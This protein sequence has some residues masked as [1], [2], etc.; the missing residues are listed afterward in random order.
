[1]ALEDGLRGSEKRS[2][3]ALSP[4]LGDESSARPQ[5]RCDVPH[6]G[7]GILNPV[8][9]SIRKHRIERFREREPH[10]IGELKLE[11]GIVLAGLSDHVGR[12]INTNDV[13]PWFRDLGGQ[14]SRTASQVKDAFAGLRR[15]QRKHVRAEVPYKRVPSF[16]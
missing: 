5:H 16:V 10:G 4:E 14:L 13:R 7:F 9:D 3:I 2:H 15:E 6:H 8:K 12:R 1:M 11:L